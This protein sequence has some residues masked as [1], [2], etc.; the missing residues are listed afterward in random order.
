MIATNA[1]LPP[2]PPLL[3]PSVTFF[4]SIPAT[5]LALAASPSF[6]KPSASSTPTNLYRRLNSH[7]LRVCKTIFAKVSTLLSSQQLL[8]HEPARRPIPADS[9]AEHQDSA[10]CDRGRVPSTIPSFATRD[11][12]SIRASN[13]APPASSRTIHSQTKLKEVE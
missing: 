12:L 5:H 1:R 2:P 8:S 10:T 3:D 11:K 6:W 13:F 4:N 9:Q 7:I